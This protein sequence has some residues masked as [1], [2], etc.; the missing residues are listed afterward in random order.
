MITAS[1]ATP[2]PSRALGI[3]ADRIHDDD[4]DDRR[5]LFPVGHRVHL[6]KCLGCPLWEL[7]SLVVDGLCPNC[8]PKDGKRVR[9][10]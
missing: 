3:I 8:Q 9:S 4:D 1:N 7:P 6:V 2:L 5:A 10:R